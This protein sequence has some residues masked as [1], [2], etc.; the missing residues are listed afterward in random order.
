MNYIALLYTSWRFRFLSGVSVP[1]ALSSSLSSTSPS[2]SIIL[3]SESC[4]GLCGREQT[5][6]HYKNSIMLN[7]LFGGTFAWRGLGGSDWCRGSFDRRSCRG[8]GILFHST[9]AGGSVKD[10]A[11]ELKVRAERQKYNLKS[12]L[13]TNASSSSDKIA[14][15][16]PAARRFT[17]LYTNDCQLKSKQTQG[18]Y[19]FAGG[20]MGGV[21]NLTDPVFLVNRRSTPQIA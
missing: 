21:E 14:L 10:G 20:S 9:L 4:L 15:D 13:G 3:S 11:S 19:F 5:W 7:I 1:S 12:H 8:L 6:M 18:T 17:L 16:D 2:T